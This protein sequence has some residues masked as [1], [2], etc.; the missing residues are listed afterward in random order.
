MAPRAPVCTKLCATDI[1]RREMSDSDIRGPMKP[2]AGRRES[3]TDGGPTRVA[4][5]D[6][7]A[8][9]RDRP[10]SATLRVDPPHL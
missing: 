9:G 8:L 2:L 6:L 5:Q 7:L 1:V 4:A 10:I 3:V